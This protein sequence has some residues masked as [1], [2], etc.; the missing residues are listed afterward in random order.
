MSK[1][2]KI[3]CTCGALQGTLK[4]PQLANRAVC[5]C[6]SCQAFPAKL[7]CAEQVLDAR[8]GTDILQTSPRFVS[9]TEGLEHLTYLQ[10]SPKGPLRWYARCCNTPI[11][12]TARSPRLAFCGLL[13]NVLGGHQVLDEH[14]GPPAMHVFVATALGEDKPKKV[15]PLLTV[16]A[17][18]RRM[19]WARLSGSYRQTPFFDEQGKPFA[20]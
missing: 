5:Y 3:S 12:N 18:I 10:I 9:F 7:E 8:G 6:K 4:D 14:F 1:V 20:T 2:L 15:L 16:A 17:F 13:H 19:L 11:G